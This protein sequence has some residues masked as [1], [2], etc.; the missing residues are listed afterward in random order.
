M[1]NWAEAQFGNC[2][3]DDKRLNKRIIKLSQEIQKQPSESLPCQ[4]GEWKD[5]KAAYRFL[6]SPSISHIDNEESALAL[7]SI[8][9]PEFIT[10]NYH[11]FRK[12]SIE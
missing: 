11:E 3:F 9:L 8:L 5:L 6:S 7:D 1:A 4:L 10:L 2:C 12:R